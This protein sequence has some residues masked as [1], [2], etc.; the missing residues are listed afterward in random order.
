VKKALGL[1]P[2]FMKRRVPKAA[3]ML[4]PVMPFIDLSSG[5]IEYERF[6]GARNRPTI[7][8][9]HE[10]LGSVAMWRD[11]P[12]KLAAATSHPVLV[13]SRFGYG[14]SDPVTLPRTPN[15]MHDEAWQVLPELREQ[16]KLDRVILL[17]HSDG[18]SIALLHAARH[19][20]DGVVVMA[21][22]V[23]VENVSIAS[24]EL[25][26][27]A[28]QSSDLPARLGKYHDDAGHAFKGWNDIWLAP[29]FRSWNIE[30]EVSRIKVPMLAMQGE[31]DEYGTLYQ[32]EEIQR[33]VPGTRLLKL[34]GV[35]HSPHKDAPDLVLSAI[36]SFLTTLPEIVVN[37]FK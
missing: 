24:I 18:A 30:A 25:A 10:G 3:S 15:Y 2:W 31:D 17:G 12:A 27:T 37:D 7:L 28:W 29:A 14:K 34:P 35:K 21:P 13:Y 11:F 19:A 1:V 8:M 16:F 6:A 23:K 33:R 5:A 26:R 9:L 4:K 22:H 20:V 36:T 32:I